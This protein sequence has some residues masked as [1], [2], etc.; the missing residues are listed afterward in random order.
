LSAHAALRAA[1]RAAHDQLDAHFSTYD[2][3]DRDN[4]GRF[5]TSHAAA[6]VPIEAALTG[7]G[8]GRLVDDWPGHRRSNALLADLADLGLAPP[9]PVAPPA[10]DDDDHILGGLYVIEGSRLGG[11]M[12]QRLVADDLPRRFLSA[13]QAKGRWRGLTATLDQRLQSPASLSR[14]VEAALATFSSFHK[15]VTVSLYE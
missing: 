9:P 7:A 13:P 4:Y 1:T 15:A 10:Y 3:G 11:Q 6:F 12:L 2:L 5:L 8:A 14:S